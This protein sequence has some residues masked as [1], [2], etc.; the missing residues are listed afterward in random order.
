M[1]T[2]VPTCRAVSST[3]TRTWQ[4]RGTDNSLETLISDAPE[5]VHTFLPAESDATCKRNAFVFLGQ[6]AT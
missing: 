4:E 6:C 2:L 5:L 1:E 3:G